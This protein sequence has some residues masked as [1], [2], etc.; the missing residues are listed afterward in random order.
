MAVP[1]GSPHNLLPCAN[2]LP[3]SANLVGTSTQ[4]HLLVM[5]LF[6][7]QKAIQVKPVLASRTTSPLL[8]EVYVRNS[9]QQAAQADQTEISPTDA[10]QTPVKDVSDK[11]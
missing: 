5:S 3:G 1:G 4:A 2:A 8:K 7:F 11:G 9:S 10:N 6:L